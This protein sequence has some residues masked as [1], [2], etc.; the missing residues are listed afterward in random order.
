MYDW[1]LWSLEIKE[2][3][4]KRFKTIDFYMQGWDDEKDETDKFYKTK[5]SDVTQDG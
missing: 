1:R 3:L 4:Q 5:I 2:C